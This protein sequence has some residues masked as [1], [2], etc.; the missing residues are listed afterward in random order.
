MAIAPCM[1]N[2]LC[3]WLKIH[4]GY[5]GQL[6]RIWPFGFICVHLGSFGFVWVWEPTQT[7]PRRAA[8]LLAKL[9]QTKPACEISYDWL[10]IHPDDDGQ[11]FRWS[12]G[13]V[14]VRLGSF[15]FIWVCLGNPNEPR[16]QLRKSCS[17]SPDRIFSNNITTY[18][19]ER[20]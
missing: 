12:S 19:N 17:K 15:G 7:I 13:F 6:F 4:P 5:Y 8:G 16:W 1:R 18:A 3:Y 14:W 10:K 20:R 2:Q 9:T 11:L